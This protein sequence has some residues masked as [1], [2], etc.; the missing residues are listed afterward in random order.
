MTNKEYF[1]QHNISFADALKEYDVNKH[2]TIEQFLYSE[3][4]KKFKPGDIVVGKERDYL[5]NIILSIDENN[6][7]VTK[8]F[9]SSHNWVMFV[10]KDDDMDDKCIK[11]GEVDIGSDVLT[12]EE[13]GDIIKSMSFDLILD[14]WK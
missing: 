3:K 6:R 2:G 7:Y 12:E 10:D 1:E 11:I 4:K 14:K 8:Y 9:R 13:K 5:V